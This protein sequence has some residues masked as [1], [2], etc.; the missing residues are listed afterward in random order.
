MKAA[1]LERYLWAARAARSIMGKTRAIRGCPGVPLANDDPLA[2]WC[3]T[4][5]IAT[6]GPKLCKNTGLKD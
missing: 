6:G 3:L 1:E 2:W 4:E 5:L